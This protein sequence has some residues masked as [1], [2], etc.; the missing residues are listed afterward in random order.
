MP[1]HSKLAASNEGPH[2]F[3]HPH[4]CA[5]FS[6]GPFKKVVC[7]ALPRTYADSTQAAVA[8]GAVPSGDPGLAALRTQVGAVRAAHLFVAVTG[9][10]GAAAFFM[11]PNKASGFLEVS[12]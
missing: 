1:A 5:G 7:K 6:A 11:E 2:P 9:S 3:T 12:S 4:A 10:S 8:P